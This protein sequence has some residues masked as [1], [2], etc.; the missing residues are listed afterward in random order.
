ML[1]LFLSRRE[2][3]EAQKRAPEYAYYYLRLHGDEAE[4]YVRGKLAGGTLSRY[5]RYLMRLVLDQLQLRG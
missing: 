2:R 5:K 4:S 3:V 1:F